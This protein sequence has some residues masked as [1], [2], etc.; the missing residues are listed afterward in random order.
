MGRLPAPSLLELTRLELRLCDS[1]VVAASSDDEAS[2]FFK[3]KVPESPAAKEK[4]GGGSVQRA[5]KGGATEQTPL[6]PTAKPKSDDDRL[7][8][9]DNA[10]YWLE[11]FVIMKHTMV[12]VGTLYTWNT[13]WQV[14][15]PGGRRGG[16]PVSRHGWE[17]GARRRLGQSHFARI[18]SCEEP[19]TGA[20]SSA[21][22]IGC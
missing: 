2:R 21:A 8:W 4:G 20:P 13:W 6:L 16:G 14:R 1:Q 3:H 22:R 18:H 9:I 11:T 7:Y 19:A 10:R 12:Y 5:G 17:T 15:S